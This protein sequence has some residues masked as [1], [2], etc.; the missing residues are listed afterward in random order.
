MCVCI[1]LLCSLVR[2]SCLWSFLTGVSPSV[3]SLFPP[4][5]SSISSGMDC[6]EPFVSAADRAGAGGAV[7][8]V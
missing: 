6:S 2:V 3:L 4:S 5:S 1:G 7:V 8:R